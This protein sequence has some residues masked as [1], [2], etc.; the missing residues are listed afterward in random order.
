MRYG[1]WR[2]TFGALA[3]VVACGDDEGF[4]PTVE[5]VAGTYEA[6]TFTAVTSAATLDLLAQGA[7]VDVT[8]AED[9]TASGRLFLPGGA[10]DGG[11]LD[12]DL[13]GTWTLSGE[14]VTFDQ[15]G[16]TFIRDVDFTA[17]ENTL[18]GE[19]S[20]QGVDLRLVMTK[21]E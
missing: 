8:L 18:T 6:T 11:N 5:N 9:G 2:L 12:E 17:G 21:T 4:S 10:E 16:D 14:T 1:S 15:A 13:T 3:L 20:F 7:T 19:G